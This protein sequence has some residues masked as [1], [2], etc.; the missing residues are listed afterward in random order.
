MDYERLEDENLSQCKQE[1]MT[2]KGDFI[3][4]NVS[5]HIHSELTST[6]TSRHGI[7][8]ICVTTL[9]ITDE[10]SKAVIIGITIASTLAQWSPMSHKG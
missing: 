5:L 2:Q 4:R 9:L 7:I 8:G 3:S 6:W 1:R 10:F